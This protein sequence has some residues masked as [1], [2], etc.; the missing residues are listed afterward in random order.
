MQTRVYE[1]SHGASLVRFRAALY[2]TTATPSEL[3]ALFGRVGVPSMR[4]VTVQAVAAGTR[5]DG[6]ADVTIEND[7]PLDNERAVFVLTTGQRVVKGVFG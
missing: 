4:G 1:E 6:F 7:R 3:G 5:W 2:A